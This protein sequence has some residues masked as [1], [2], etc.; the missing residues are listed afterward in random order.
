MDLGAR[1]NRD[2]AV[3]AKRFVRRLRGGSQPVL[4]E[5]SDGLQYV[6]KFQN[7][8]QGP[9]LLFNE[10]AGTELFGQA[11]LPVPDWR[12]IRI[13]ERFLRSTPE[14]WLETAHGLVRPQAGLCFGSLFLEPEQ[15]RIFEILSGGYFSR[16]RSRGDFWTAWVLDVLAENT[17]HRQALF[18]EEG[19]SRLQT[20][21]I[22]HGHL[23]GGARGA[24][25]PWYRAS[26][27]I[28]PRVYTEAGEPEAG[29][30]E[31][32]I[33]R[34]D[35]RRLAKRVIALPEAWKP[36]SALLRFGRMMERL[37]NVE[38]VG[39]VTRF[40][41]GM[42]ATLEQ[43]VR[44]QARECRTNHL[45]YRSEEPDVRAP[46]PVASCLG[47]QPGAGRFVCLTGRRGPQAVRAPWAKA[48]GF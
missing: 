35:L 31:E 39:E 1:M 26:R 29:A 15:S 43:E 19:N 28:D 44:S 40:V 14:C 9:N 11:G 16:V 45:R 24:S 18:V 47:L 8:F 22:D 10:V 13:T 42:T 38:T 34:I 7:N 4:I 37:S 27:Y 25:V 46:L 36:A 48:A 3:Q 17:D 41:L 23:L 21:F 30:V 12:P 20:F 32:S 5:A 2:E 33:R 6:V